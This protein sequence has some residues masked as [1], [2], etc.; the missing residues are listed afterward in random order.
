MPRTVETVVYQFDELSDR[1]KERAR[2]WYRDGRFIDT[3]WAECTL[4]DAATIAGILGIRLDTRT[5]KLWGGGTRQE[6]IIYWSIFDRD[7]GAGFHGRYYYARGAAKKIREYAPADKELHRI[8]DTL[9]RE[10]RR[11][12]YN[13]GARIVTAGRD[14]LDV[15]VEDVECPDRGLTVSAETEE[16]IGESIRDFAHW[17]VCQLEREA[18]YQSSDETVDENIRANEYE[19]TEEGERA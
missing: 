18:E 4:D 17:I 13:L 9:Q 11:Y 2:Q 3:D 7:R 5:V 1:A 16:T 10:Q 14:G 19:F 12:F 6:P 15:R 8:A